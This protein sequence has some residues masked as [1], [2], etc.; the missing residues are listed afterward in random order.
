MSEQ[1]VAKVTEPQG[2]RLALT[3]WVSFSIIWVGVMAT[4]LY[5]LRHTLAARTDY[6]ILLPSLFFFATWTWI[7]F[8]YGV[9]KRLK[10]LPV[11]QTR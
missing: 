10:G 3:L 8:A 6:R 2:K 11:K 5:F 9:G 7:R 1:I 4:P